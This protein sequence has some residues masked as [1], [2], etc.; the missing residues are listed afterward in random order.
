MKTLLL[1]VIATCLSAPSMQAG[2]EMVYARYG[3]PFEMTGFVVGQEGGNCIPPK[4]AY[5]LVSTDHR[6]KVWLCAVDS[7]ELA[8][9]RAM[10]SRGIYEVS[11]ILRQ[12]A[13][14]PYVEVESV[15]WY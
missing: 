10:L 13:E 1:T 8:L 3:E 15:R 7:N 5:E 14:R 12:D 11:G 2:T 6:N 4:F 9:R